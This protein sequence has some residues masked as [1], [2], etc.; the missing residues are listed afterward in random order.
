L[1]HQVDETTFQ[2]TP[3][4]SLVTRLLFTSARPTNF[5]NNRAGFTCHRIWRVFL[6][7]V[8]AVMMKKYPSAGQRIATIIRRASLYPS[9]FQH[10]R[11]VKIERSMTSDIHRFL[12]PESRLI[13]RERSQFDY[14]HRD[15]EN[16]LSANRRV[17][18]TL[19]LEL[20]SNNNN[21][22]RT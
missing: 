5:S 19:I 11:F 2:T 20:I 15:N 9:V 16:D 13:N 7:S 10:S 17:Y 8:N 3:L 22:S 1:S 14:C 6:Y 12:I 21:S 4:K 18:V